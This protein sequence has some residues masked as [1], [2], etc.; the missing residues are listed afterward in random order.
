MRLHIAP[1]EMIF[2][3]RNRRA[4]SEIQTYSCDE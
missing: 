2:D 4:M 3:D 1:R